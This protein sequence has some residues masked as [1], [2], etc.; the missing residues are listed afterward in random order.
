VKC[1]TCY[2]SELVKCAKY[3]YSISVPLW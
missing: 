1:A 2:Y 3:L